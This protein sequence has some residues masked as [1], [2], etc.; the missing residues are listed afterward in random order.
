MGRRVLA[1]VVVCIGIA[2]LFVACPNPAVD[3]PTAEGP[4]IGS[5][6]VVLHQRLQPVE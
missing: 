5:Q 3:D 2:L 6:D 4:P 1:L